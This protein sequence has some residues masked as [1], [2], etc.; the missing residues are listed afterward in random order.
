MESDTRPAKNRV[1]EQRSNQRYDHP[2]EQPQQAAAP[3]KRENKPQSDHGR[4]H[5][6]AI[7]PLIE[8]AFAAS[9]NSDSVCARMLPS[10]S[11]RIA[12]EML[13]APRLALR[14]HCFTATKA[15]RS[16]GDPGC[17]ITYEGSHLLSPKFSSRLHSSIVSMAHVATRYEHR[18]FLAFFAVERREFCKAQC[19][20]RDN[21]RNRAQTCGLLWKTQR[22]A[23]I[24]RGRTLAPLDR[25]D[26]STSHLVFKSGAP[27]RPRGIEASFSMRTLAK[28]PI[29]TSSREFERPARSSSCLRTT[30]PTR[31]ASP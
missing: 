23:G 20:L 11:L 26:R 12:L 27:D 30:G 14:R 22:S 9:A 28:A 19:G 6:P 3:G 29:S 10:W 1:A 13:H 25:T 31:R 4:R 7:A 17:G 21:S 18:T 15:V 24:T 8:T 5:T 16:R 2:H